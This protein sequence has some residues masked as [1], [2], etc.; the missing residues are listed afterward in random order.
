M[1]RGY[2]GVD[3][4]RRQ[5]SLGTEQLTDPWPVFYPDQLEPEMKDKG[6]DIHHPLSGDRPGK[7]TGKLIVKSW[8][9][10]GSYDRPVDPGELR[11]LRQEHRVLEERKKKIMPQ[12]NDATL[13]ISEIEPMPDRQEDRRINHVY[14]SPTDLTPVAPADS[15]PLNATTGRT[16]RRGHCGGGRP[17]P[18]PACRLR[19]SFSQHSGELSDDEVMGR[20]AQPRQ[21][22][23]PSTFN[24]AAPAPSRPGQPATDQAM[25]SSGGIFSRLLSQNQHRRCT[26]GHHPMILSLPQ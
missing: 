23:Q 22:Q 19:I 24:Q 17:S 13:G 21:P 3:E 7:P 10:D 20:Q 16:L 15:L 14:M 25:A 11:R 5:D 26:A 1:E 12:F 4:G 2:V 8:N 18:T 9:A 6:W